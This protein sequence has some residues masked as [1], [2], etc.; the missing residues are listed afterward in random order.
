MAVTFSVDTSLHPLWRQKEVIPKRFIPGNIP[1]NRPAR[2]STIT[3]IAC[4]GCPQ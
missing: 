2:I 3:L 4:T 1:W